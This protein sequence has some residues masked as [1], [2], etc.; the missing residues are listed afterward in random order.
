MH[1]YSEM[2]CSFYL[3]KVTCILK[4]TLGAFISYLY[5]HLGDIVLNI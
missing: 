4:E 2:S 3:K 5:Y 1:R